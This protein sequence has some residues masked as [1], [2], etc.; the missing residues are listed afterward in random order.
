MPLISVVIATFNCAKFLGDALNSVLVQTFKDCEVLIVDDG[1]TDETK[2]IVDRYFK[3]GR[4]RYIYIDHKGQAFAKNRGIR[5]AR[6]EFVAFLDADDIWIPTKLEKQVP[7]FSQHQIGLVYGR[8]SLINEHGYEKPFIHPKFHRGDALESIFIENYVCFSSAMVRKSV[9][10]E[11][12]MFDEQLKMGIDYDL[13]IRL[14]ARYK[15]DYVDEVLVKYRI[16]GGQ[17]SQKTGLRLETAWHI[18]DK[19]LK[20]DEI[21]AKLSKR[22][23]REATAMTYCTTGNWYAESGDVGKAVRNYISSLQTYPLYMNS[24]KGIAKLLMPQSIITGLNRI[25]VNQIALRR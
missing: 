25:F 14:A 13:W 1:S 24:L 19:A 12:G 17:L 6:G 8:R 15:F 10:D 4:L 22:A 20:D 5:E 18:M 7:L 3:D 11:V 16:W 2:E 9:L 23:I 21:R